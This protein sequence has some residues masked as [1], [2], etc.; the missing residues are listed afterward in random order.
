MAI[1]SFRTS[2]A[3][4]NAHRR[5]FTEDRKEQFLWSQT[6]VALQYEQRGGGAAQCVA[7]MPYGQKNELV[8]KNRKN[9]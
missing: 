9:H 4:H 3:V 6:N 5:D 2:S 8:S 1:E 7:K